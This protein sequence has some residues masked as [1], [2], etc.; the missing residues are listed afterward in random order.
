VPEYRIYK[1]VDEHIYASP[2]IVACETDDEAI[3]K[4]CQQ[5]DGGRCDSGSSI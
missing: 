1:I 5:L 2:G 4:A 3:S